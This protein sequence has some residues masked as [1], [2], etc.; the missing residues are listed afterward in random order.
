[1]SDSKAAKAAVE[2]VNGTVSEVKAAKMVPLAKKMERDPFCAAALR[3][4]GLPKSRAGAIYDAIA[5][6]LAPAP[7]VDKPKADKPKA[8]K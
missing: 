8:D 4:F 5:G 3:Q 2:A 7:K 6:A 1:M